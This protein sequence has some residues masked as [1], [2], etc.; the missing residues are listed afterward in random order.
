MSF[1]HLHV[2]SQYSV[3]D[4]MSK[5]PDFVSKCLKTDMHALALTDHGNMY[6][7]KEF[8]DHCKKVNKEAGEI[9]IKPIVGCE[10]YCARRGRHS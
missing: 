9:V 8:L 1:T 3:L 2:H 10:T 6:G 7:I 4:G 5:I